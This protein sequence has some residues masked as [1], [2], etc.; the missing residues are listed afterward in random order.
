MHRHDLR[1]GLGLERELL[2]EELEGH[3]AERV[4][5]GRGGQHGAARLLGREVLRRADE[6]PVDRAMDVAR[7]LLR[8]TPVE[9]LGAL[10]AALHGDQEDVVELEVAVD[11]P[12]AV[13]GD[14][15]VADL[16]QELHDAVRQ[17]LGLVGELA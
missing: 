11:D 13:R 12:R 1:G 2:E 9:Q 5:I 15:R 8:D 17:D 16:D 6:L 3:H 10:D 14:E 4:H 7:D